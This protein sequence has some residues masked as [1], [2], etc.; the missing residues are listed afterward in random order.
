MKLQYRPL[1]RISQEI[2]VIS[3]VYGPPSQRD[4]AVIDVGSAAHEDVIKCQLW[5]LS[6]KSKKK[7]SVTNSVPLNWAETADIVDL[8]PP[9]SQ[10]LEYV[11]LSYTWGSPNQTAKIEVNGIQ[12]PNLEVALGVLR[13]K[14]A[15]RQGCALW[16]DALCIDQS[17]LFERSEVVGRMRDIY[18]RARSVVLWIGRED[19]D[20]A[21]A[22]QLITT[23]SAAF[24]KDFSI[25]LA[26]CLRDGE[27]SIPPGSW[28]ALEALM[29][30][31]YW[32]RV[33]ILQEVAMGNR[34][35]PVLCGNHLVTW[36]ETYD[37][38]YHFSSRHV[39]LVFSCIAKECS[40]IGVDPKVLKRNHIIHGAGAPA[41]DTVW[42]S[43]S[44]F[45]AYFG[46]GSQVHGDESQR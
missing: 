44:A 45:L 16:V 4:H 28:A 8:P 38:L 43:A 34:S 13:D 2:R 7:E 12:V 10:C 41:T 32:T 30:R 19:K 33:W 9:R 29:Q 39:D 18:K 22:I 15:M 1:N 11:A 46:R 5:H 31:P 26:R 3:F 42:A 21:K 14:P 20:G 23:L 40:E 27:C 17:N 36:G 6:M 37:A 35:T 25:R 24:A